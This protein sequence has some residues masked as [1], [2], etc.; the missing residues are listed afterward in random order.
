MGVLDAHSGELNQLKRYNSISSIKWF[1]I[2]EYFY[3]PKKETI[4][5]FSHK[6]D[7]YEFLIPLKTIPIIINDKSN[8]CGEVGYVFP[9][10][11]QTIHGIVFPLDKSECLDITIDKSYLDALK[12]NLGFSGKQF[13]NR[14]FLAPGF[15]DTV[16]EFQKEIN[17]ANCN[18]FRAENL[19]KMMTTTLIVDG[20]RADK[21]TKRPEKQYRKNIKQMI[22]YMYNNFKNQDLDIAALA[23]KSGYSLAYFTKAFKAYM[24]ETPI[25]H[26]NKLRISEAKSIMLIEHR[27]TFENIYREVGYKNFSSFTE[28]FKRVS[29]MSPS[30][31]KKRYMHK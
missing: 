19:A 30:E 29:N 6:H 5:S 25:A 16:K 14:F 8:Y 12:E 7:E 24:G 13:S 31:F 9:V 15:L 3:D 10:N 28:A 18:L 27:K 17:R 22:A 26:L 1:S 2:A 21:G 11:P 23:E 4:E 20:L